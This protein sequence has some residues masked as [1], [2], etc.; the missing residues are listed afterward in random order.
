MDKCEAKISTIELW[1]MWQKIDFE[2]DFERFFFLHSV[3]K[4]KAF[5]SKLD[6]ESKKRANLWFCNIP[7][8]QELQFTVL[9]ELHWLVV[10]SHKYHTSVLVQNTS[11]ED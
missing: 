2:T 10:F 3:W 5:H 4:S 8:E 1:E 6:I 7:H 9:P 11:N